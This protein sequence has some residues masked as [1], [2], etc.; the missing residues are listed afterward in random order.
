MVRSVEL[1]RAETR[2]RGGAVR[3]AAAGE[4]QTPLRHR[5]CAARRKAA[6]APR[7]RVS[8]RTSHHHA[9]GRA[10]KPARCS[11]ARAALRTD[12]SSRALPTSWRPRG[13]PSALRPAGTLIAGR[14]ARLAG[15]AKTSFR[16]MAMGSFDFSPSAKAAE[17]AVGVRRRSQLSQ[18]RS[19]SRAMRARTFWAWLKYAS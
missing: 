9:S 19:K 11:R 16:Y 14:P 13:R 3:D 15:T 5:D 10:V 12:C 1:V 2:R 4:H 6:D 17:G 7:L 8:A 18:A